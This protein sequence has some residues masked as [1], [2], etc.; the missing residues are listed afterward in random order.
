MLTCQ[1]LRGAVLGSGALLIAAWMAEL[2]AASGLLPGVLTGYIGFVLLLVSASGL[3][4]T[5]LLSLLPTNA[6]RLVRC[7]H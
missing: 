6:E 4:L 7:E 1:S 2:L 5:F 3:G